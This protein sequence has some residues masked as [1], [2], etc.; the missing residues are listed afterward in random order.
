MTYE[1]ER[2]WL[3]QL[4]I[5]NDYVRIPYANG[6]SYASQFLFRELSERGHEVTVVGPQDRDATEAELPPRHVSLPSIQLRNHPGVQLALP[7]RAGLRSL[8]RARFDLVLAQASS[9]LLDAGV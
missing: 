2:R 8:K 5:I 7:S 3:E 1:N 4:A 6:S 9:A